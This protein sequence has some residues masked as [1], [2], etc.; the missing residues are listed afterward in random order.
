MPARRV[1]PRWPL[2]D[3]RAMHSALARLLRLCLWL[4]PCLALPP[5]ADALELRMLVAWDETYP[6]VARIAE[7]FARKVDET[8]H[9]EVTFTLT[10]PDG[11]PPFEQFVPASL[12]IFDLLFTHGGF[13]LDV[14]GMGLALDALT[15]DAKR[16]RESG[17]WDAVD[18]AYQRH[19]LKLIAI[20]VAGSGYQVFLR[21]AVGE[22]CDL[23]G[24]H[25]RAAPVYQQ[26]LAAVGAERVALP[27]G[28]VHD[29]LGDKRL[30]G[31][32]WSTLGTLDYHW[33]EVNRFLLRP[34][35]GAVSHLLLMNL[36]TWQHLPLD[37]Q[38]LLLEQGE[39]LETRAE[40]RLRELA[41]AE[42]NQLTVSGMQLTALCKKGGKRLRRAWAAGVWD[43]AIEK[44]G[45]EARALRALA[46]KAELTPTEK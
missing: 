14:T 2:R 23:H 22:S 27:I 3:N 18:R 35:F 7:R 20:P 8:S 38:K 33:F 36:D 4:L 16:L 24:R 30:D 13:H 6:G 10:G 41:A 26:M 15:G 9:G 21:E 43:M 17:I 5:A 37:L 11:I 25:I 19:G 45:D 29:A 1:A 40:R 44:S 34:T 31:V 39:A 12:G 42:L 28:E 46:E 32:A